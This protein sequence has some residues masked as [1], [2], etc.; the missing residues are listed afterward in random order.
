MEVSLSV[1]ARGNYRIIETEFHVSVTE[2]S[3]ENLS[4]LGDAE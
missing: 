1:Y 2:I 4:L 3:F